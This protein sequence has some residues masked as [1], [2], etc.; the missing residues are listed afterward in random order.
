MWPKYLRSTSASGEATGASQTFRIFS[1]AGANRA[2][3]RLLWSLPGAKGSR[4]FGELSEQYKNFSKKGR[5][6]MLTRTHTL[7]IHNWKTMALLVL[8]VCCFFPADTFA[9]IRR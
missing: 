2:H 7:S 8:A 4:R 1:G 6:A 3:R 5:L 9:Q